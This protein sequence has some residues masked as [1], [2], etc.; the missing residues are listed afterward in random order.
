M[1]LST[2]FGRGRRRRWR[3]T[4][5]THG[6][7]EWHLF[8][9][10]K[11]KPKPEVHKTLSR[12]M[13]AWYSFDNSSQKHRPHI[14]ICCCCCRV[15][16]RCN[17][18]CGQTPSPLNCMSDLWTDTCLTF[19]SAEFCRRESEHSEELHNECKLGTAISA[20]FAHNFL[21][22]GTFENVLVQRPKQNPRCPPFAP[23]HVHCGT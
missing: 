20:L 12:R 16:M 6:S 18:F 13:L 19:P 8:A 4:Y 15:Q 17:S 14:P 5:V 3:Q 1:C 2:F 23:R 22:F 9:F 21:T 7:R 11:L 10:P